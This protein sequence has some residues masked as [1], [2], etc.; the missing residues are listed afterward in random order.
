[1]SYLPDWTD[2]RI[3]QAMAD[4]DKAYPAD[5]LD[6]DPGIVLEYHDAPEDEPDDPKPTIALTTADALEYLTRTMIDIL[7]NVGVH[8][9]L[10]ESAEH[11][12]VLMWRNALRTVKNA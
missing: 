9:N 5:D 1:M 10:C 11:Q 6:G 8:P 12:I 7:A 3:R 2:R 4:Y